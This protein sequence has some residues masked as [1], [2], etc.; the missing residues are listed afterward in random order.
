LRRDRRHR[1][2]LRV[3]VGFLVASVFC[4]FAITFVHRYVIPFPGP[5]SG[6]PLATRTTFW[7][8]MHVQESLSRINDVW[9]V[10]RMQWLAFSESWEWWG[11]GPADILP[12]SILMPLFA[13][14]L[15]AVFLGLATLLKA[16]TAQAIVP[17]LLSALAV[18]GLYFL[19]ARVLQSTLSIAFW[20]F[21]LSIVAIMTAMACVRRGATL[22]H[23]NQTRA[24]G[25]AHRIETNGDLAK[26]KQRQ[27]IAR[28]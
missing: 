22:Q 25:E 12:S 6:P 19:G 27:P 17:V 8:F 7:S 5:Y 26:R 15:I 10:N 9:V 3:S 14:Q 4:P 23:N 13:V 16:N 21:V 2:L 18:N 20:L 11:P 28:A 24:K 1:L